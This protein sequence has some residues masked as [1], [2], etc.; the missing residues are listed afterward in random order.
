MIGILGGMGPESTAYTYM[1]IIRRCQEEYGARMDSDFPPIIIYSMPVPDVVE[2]GSNDAAVLALLDSGIRKLEAAGA[3]FSF[4]A[5]N[6]MQGFVPELR[7]R[8]RMLSLVEETLMQAKLSGLADWGILG[9]EVTLR[10][11]YYQQ[12]FNDAGLRALTP[13]PNEQAE[14]T[15]AIREIL[16]G[17]DIASPRKRLQAVAGALAVRGANGIVLACTDLPLA[18]GAD[19]AGMMVLDTADISAQAALLRWRR[20]RPGAGGDSPF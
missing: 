19:D 6:T 11:G 7:K 4:I 14:V 18:F 10:K 17:T 8:Y 9:T 16:A 2:E 20:E 15:A 1:R 3:T 12:A 13:L 5:C